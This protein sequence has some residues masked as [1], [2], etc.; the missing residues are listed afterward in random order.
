[1]LV[2]GLTGGIASGKSTVTSMLAAYGAQVIDA[3]QLAREV[4]A[5]GREALAEIAKEFGPPVLNPDGSLDRA[6]LGRIV[7]GSPAKRRR[8]EE[9]TH[10]RIAARMREQLYAL[11]SQNQTFPVV[12]DVPLLFETPEILHLCDYTIVVWVPESL[13]IHRLMHRDGLSRQD[14]L[15]RIRAQMPL[16]EKRR[17]ADAVIDNSC[18][19]V[20]TQSQVRGLWTRLLGDVDAPADH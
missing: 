9:I 1:M 11:E 12:L 13:Q 10:P 17:L 5:L 7:F 2:L 4:V 16:D 8:L 14:A 20:A 6:A 18:S 3:D 19:L 15:Q